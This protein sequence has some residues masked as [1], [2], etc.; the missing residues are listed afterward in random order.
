[1]AFTCGF[2][3][4]D[5]GDRKYNAEQIS[6]IF[7]GIIAD[8]VFATIGDH[9]VVTPGTGMQ[10][11]V[12]T[13]KAWFDHTWNVNDSSYSLEIAKSDVT[14]D[15][16]DAVVLETN[17]S[18]SVRFNGF[19]VI[20]GAMSSTP[21]KPTLTNTETIHQHPLAWI[22]VKAG[23]TAITASMIENA[24]GKT[25]CPFVTGV[26]EVTSIDDLFNQWNGEFDEWFANLKTQLSGDVAANLQ[27]QIDENRDAIDKNGYRF[28]DSI[29]TYEDKFHTVEVDTKFPTDIYQAMPNKTNYYYGNTIYSI[30]WPTKINE[31]S[32]TLKL[33]G[34]DFETD[35]IVLNMDIGND[36]WNHMKS[37]DPNAKLLVSASEESR[38]RGHTKDMI[39]WVTVVQY[40]PTST[41]GAE[42]K[43]VRIVLD[44]NTYNIEFVDLSSVSSYNRYRCDSYS[45]YMIDTVNTN[46]YTITLLDRTFNT[47]KTINLTDLSAPSGAK[48]LKDAIQLTNDILYVPIYTTERIHY[49]TKDYGTTWTKLNIPSKYSKYNF[50]LYNSTVDDLVYFV[51]FS[52]VGAVLGF[53][54]V[55]F[56]VTEFSSIFGSGWKS[57]GRQI[58]TLF[59]NTTLVVFGTHGPTH[60]SEIYKIINNTFIK[61]ADV[62]MPY[63]GDGE[64]TIPTFILENGVPI[65]LDNNTGI[66]YQGT[67]SSKRKV[68]KGPIPY[69]IIYENY[70]LGAKT[71]IEIPFD[72]KLIA[73]SDGLNVI[74]KIIPGPNVLNSDT[75]YWATTNGG[76][77]S[78]SQRTSYVAGNS[79]WVENGSFGSQKPYIVKVGTAYSYSLPD[80][81]VIGFDTDCSI[82]LVR[83]IKKG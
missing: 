46:D 29:I 58:N 73:I 78:S 1:M 81:Q 70:K 34:Y 28:E 15:R 42:T 62:E 75:T 61:I 4:S 7:D 53:D 77:S 55:N 45:T 37:I 48:F 30:G 26:V 6:A 17:H 54:D 59:N 80:R 27:R 20:R 31:T 33:F 3:N 51:E 36:L 14:L 16:I 11:L 44:L 35:T 57:W 5:R 38:D 72:T 64:V 82:S 63:Y 47:F 8:G 69:G 74:Y 41:S 2:F 83:M 49:L 43:Y 18:D 52:S 9:M 56:T 23:A 12:G 66:I 19:K 60:E 40:R 65:Y 13:G 32:L 50:T 10:V 76:S 25:E 67:L 79:Y 21:V 22:R 71:P 39:A 24:V 68:F